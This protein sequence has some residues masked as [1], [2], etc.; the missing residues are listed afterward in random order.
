[1]LYCGLTVNSVVVCDSFGVLDFGLTLPFY[2]L[3]CCLD[4]FCW[5]WVL[6]WLCLL[7]CLNAFWLIFWWLCFYG[8]Y[9]ADF[10]LLVLCCV[11]VA[12]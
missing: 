11:W 10:V 6:V 4:C 9:V 5:V 8:L 1:M 2:C 12:C 3:I 7:Y